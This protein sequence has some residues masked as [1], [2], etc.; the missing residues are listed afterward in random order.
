MENYFSSNL[1]DLQKKI[2]HSRIEARERTQITHEKTKTRA[3][4]KANP[5]PFYVGQ[6][7][8]V[9]LKKGLHKMH[10]RDLT[11]IQISQGDR[12]AYTGPYKV[13]A[14]HLPNLTIETS[15]NKTQTI[16]ANSAKP[17]YPNINDESETASS[18]SEDEEENQEEEINYTNPQASTSSRV[19]HVSIALLQILIFFFLLPITLGNQLYSVQPID[20][21]N[22]V[23]INQKGKAQIIIDHYSVLT[24]L[25]FPK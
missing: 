18:S 9:Y 16:H 5:K 23:F 12:A 15:K 1:T 6:F 8:W 7:V 13:T 19:N 24:Y 14:V 20:T 25:I 17:F 3:D 4:K 22:G 10:N 11:S 2:Q 21:R